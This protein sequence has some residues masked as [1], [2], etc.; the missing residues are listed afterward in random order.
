[1]RIFFSFV[2]LAV[3]M[4]AAENGLATPP[5]GY[6]L[7][8]QDEFR[9]PSL[10]LTKWKPDIYRRDFAKL[11]PDA[12]QTGADGLKIRTYTENGIHYTGFM[13][14][15]GLFSTTYGYFES[16]IRFHGAPGEHCAFWL[17]PQKLGSIIGDPHQAGV[18]TDIIEHRV[19]DGYGEDIS[20]LAAFNLH[21]DG[22]EKDHK[23]VGSKWLSPDSLNEA[24]HVYAVLWTPEIYVF[25]VD[26]VERWRSDDAVSHAPEHVRLTCEVKGK[27]SWAGVV[28]DQGYG[29]RGKNTF[30]MDVDWV[31]VWQKVP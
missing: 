16:R 5:E 24:W 7:V 23:H 28:P 12:I 4:L 11:T 21:W 6:R 25:Y 18:E 19:N 29:P 22:Y 30:G 17:Q 20:H 31:R 3:V 8:W 13:T 10:D 2:C 9:E 26:G 15:K 1:M 27:H 14:S